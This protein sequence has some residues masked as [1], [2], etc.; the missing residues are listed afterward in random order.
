MDLSGCISDR[1]NQPAA[2]LVVGLSQLA[3]G[4]P[5]PELHEWLS[6]KESNGWHTGW[7]QLKRRFSRSFCAFFANRKHLLHFL[8]FVCITAV[9]Q[10][11]AT[12]KY[13]ADFRK[14]NC[15][16]YLLLLLNLQETIFK[17][18]D[19]INLNISL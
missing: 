16:F 15:V 6:I 2:N 17:L 12:K 19:K 5:C 13:S 14:L 11:C 8:A 1:A 9:W 4:K 3:A 7:V 18:V 10:K